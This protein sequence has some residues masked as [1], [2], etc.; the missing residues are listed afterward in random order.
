MAALT[1][2]ADMKEAEL[3]LLKIAARRLEIED[4]GERGLAALDLDPTFGFELG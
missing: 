3:T 1:K 4:A 2:D